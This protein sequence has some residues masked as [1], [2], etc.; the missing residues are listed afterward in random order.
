MM[1][2]MIVFVPYKSLNTVTSELHVHNVLI[3]IRVKMMGNKNIV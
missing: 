1:L 2:D 3:L